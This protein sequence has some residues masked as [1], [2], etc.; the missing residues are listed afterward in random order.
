M[1]KNAFRCDGFQIFFI[2]VIC[3]VGNCPICVE[4]LNI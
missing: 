1:L 2:F 3:K 4:L